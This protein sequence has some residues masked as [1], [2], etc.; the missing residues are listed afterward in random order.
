MAKTAIAF[1]GLYSRR[2]Q[3]LCQP[4]GLALTSFFSR[5]CRK[6]EARQGPARPATEVDRH[7]GAVLSR[8][9]HIRPAVRCH[10]GDRCNQRHTLPAMAG[11]QVVPYGSPPPGVSHEFS[12]TWWGRDMLGGCPRIHGRVAHTATPRKVIAPYVM[13]GSR[14]SRT[15]SPRR[16]MASTVS[17][18]AIPGKV[19]SHQATLM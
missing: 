11:R 8:A 19:E 12:G 4:A 7:R 15:R 10:S 6:S 1:H 14:M 17:K 18:I 16:L 13:R 5:G 9:R 2:R 3:N